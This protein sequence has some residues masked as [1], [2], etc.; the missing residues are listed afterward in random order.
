ME[1]ITIGLSRTKFGLANYVEPLNS[2]QSESKTLAKLQQTLQHFQ[3]YNTHTHLV[4]D[5]N[6]SIFH[7]TPTQMISVIAVRIYMVIFTIQAIQITEKYS[8]AN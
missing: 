2:N 7:L 4:N 6:C 1:N 5:K 8:T 3:K